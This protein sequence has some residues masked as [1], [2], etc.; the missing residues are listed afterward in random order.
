MIYFY[1]AVGLLLA[2]SL[3]VLASVFGD[4]RDEANGKK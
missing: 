4:N 2:I 3:A 1:W